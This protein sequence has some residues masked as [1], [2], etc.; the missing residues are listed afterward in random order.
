MKLLKKRILQIA[1]IFSILAIFVCMLAFIMNKSVDP[2]VGLPI[3]FSVDSPQSTVVLLEDPVLYPDLFCVEFSSIEHVTDFI[4]EVNLAVENLLAEIALTDKYSAGAITLMVEEVDRLTNEQTYAIRQ[5]DIFTKWAEKEDEYYYATKT[6]KYLKNLGYSDVACA[7]ILGNLMAECGG[8][9]LV[10]R[11]LVYD[12]SGN[13][14]GM[15]QWS[16][17]YYPAVNG[18]SF[19]EQ[20]DFY[21]KTSLN[22][23]AIWGDNFKHGFTIE[24]FNELTDPRE[25]ALAF[26]KIYE[27][28]A[29]WTYKVRQSYA[30]VAY[31][32]FVLDFKEVLL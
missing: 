30:E 18:V 1:Y 4:T 19:E 5:R 27:R 28:C 16:T 8:N 25:A 13:Y 9:T 17:F 6:W 12:D 11:P 21:A 22:E 3:G 7:G 20:L 2:E 31:K 10:L 26:A 32:Y 15:F 24:D 14:Y 23:F 29:S